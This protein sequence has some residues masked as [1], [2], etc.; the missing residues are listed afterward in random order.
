MKLLIITQTVDEGDQLLGFFISWIK[1]FAGKFEKITILCLNEGGHSLPP[2]V[3]VVCLGKNRGKSKLRQFFNFQFSI[4][5]LRN[6]YDAVFVHM[7]PIWVVLG[8]PFWRLANKKI[9]FWYTHKS[10]T[11]KL[12][13][14]EKLADVIFT[15]S[16]ESFRLPSRNL[17]VTGHGIDTNFFKPDP[18]NDQ[19]QT[20]NNLRLLSVG[21]IS[22][23]KNYETLIG[24]AKLLKDEGTDFSV[25]MV[26]EAALK[27]MRIMNCE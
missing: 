15:A 16:K 9:F 24:A 20:T 14:A 23:V 25:T 18:T 10:V 13:I 11:P 12:K 19:Q 3:G 17:I 6:D 4:F 21:R 7:N 26:G 2:N 22:P 5:N 27:K 8:G 1:L